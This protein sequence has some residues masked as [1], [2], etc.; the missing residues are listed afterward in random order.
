MRMR[1]L[2]SISRVKMMMKTMVRVY[3]ISIKLETT[4]NV[5]RRMMKSRMMRI[6]N[7]LQP[8]DENRNYSSISF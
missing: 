5:T 1:V 8:H 6:E 4:I 7:D 2:L 3:L